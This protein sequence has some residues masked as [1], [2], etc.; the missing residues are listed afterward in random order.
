MGILYVLLHCQ[1]WL[2]Q[3]PRAMADIIASLQ[4]ILEYCEVDLPGYPAGS[5]GHYPTL[6][7]LKGVS[8]PADREP[9]VHWCHGAPGAVFLW[10]KAY[11]VFSHQSYLDAALRASEVVWQRGLL[12]KGPG[13]C[14]GV[15]GNAYALLRLWKTTQDARYLDRAQLFASFIASEAGQTDWSKPDHPASLYE[16]AAGAICLLA[17]LQAVQAVMSGQASSRGTVAAA[18]APAGPVGTPPTGA[19][20]A[21]GLVAFPLYEMWG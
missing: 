13:L 11:E 16:G 4:Y 14:H 21:A 3:D 5:G 8:Y 12:K 6:M 9:L 18:E 2:Q 1:Q 19:A 15:A 20:A 10:C 7:Q 17:E